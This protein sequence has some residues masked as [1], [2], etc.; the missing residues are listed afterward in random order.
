[1]GVPEYYREDRERSQAVERRDRA[2][3]VQRVLYMRR[4][5][6]CESP[7]ATRALRVFSFGR[8]PR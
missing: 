1:M 7:G 3:L 6:A 8:R 2:A 4:F 5:L